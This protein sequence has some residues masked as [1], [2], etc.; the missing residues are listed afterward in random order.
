[1]T[2]L[3]LAACCALCAPNPLP[4]PGPVGPELP[5]EAERIVRLRRTIESNGKQLGSF[6]AELENPNS[7]YARTEAEFRA[8][9]GEMDDL[10][11]L[12]G[13]LRTKGK[14]DEATKKEAER[15]ELAK[16]WQQAHDRF[17][18][19]IQERKT[20]REKAVALQQKIDRDRKVLEQLENGGQEKP[21]APEPAAKTEATPAAAIPAA[22]AGKPNKELVKAR[23]RVQEKEQALAEAEA[24]ARAV[25]ERVEQVRKQIDLES[26]SLETVR[27]KSDVA[28]KTLTDLAEALSKRRAEKA[29]EAELKDLE[30]RWREAEQAFTQTRRESRRSNDRLTQLQRELAGLQDEQMAA[31]READQRKRESEAAAKAVAQLQNPFTLHNIAQWFI[32]HGPK[33]VFIVLAMFVLYRLVNLFSQ[34]IVRIVAQAGQRGTEEDSENRAQ[35]LVGVFRNAA[36]AV[37]LGGGVLLFLEAAGIPV[38]P[39]MGGAAILG[40]AVAF[41]AQNLIRDYFSGFMVLLEDQ[42]GVKD[43]VKIGDVSGQVENLTLRMTVL[44]DIEGVVH[45]IPHGTIT[46]VSN[47]THGWSRAFFVLNIGLGEN[48]DRVMRELL[49]LARAMRRDPAFGPFIL[50]DPE[51]LGVDGFGESSLRIKFFLKTRPLHQWSVKRELLRRIKLRFDA[52]GI[53]LAPSKAAAPAPQPPTGER[54]A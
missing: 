31:L 12:A 43:V 9:D 17:T 44:R 51:M 21:A 11:K 32:D 23:E 6:Q 24:R 50:D 15:Q 54:A 46:R 16:R 45:F 37:V 19:A 47:L 10:A 3:L 42:Y 48:P 22:E 7:D 5:T 33:L 39:L 36:S 1:M 29:A 40:L 14:A 28:H 30:R 52:V 2:P 27:Q 35:T 53:G 13:R 4:D 49:E 38:V 41:G 18:L 34:Q 25:T 20:L 8:L 26:K